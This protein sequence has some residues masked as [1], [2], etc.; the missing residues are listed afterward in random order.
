ML[1]G[2]EIWVIKDDVKGGVCWEEQGDMNVCVALLWK[3][4][5]QAWSWVEILQASVST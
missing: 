1:Y 3:T 2:N 5:Q 4:V